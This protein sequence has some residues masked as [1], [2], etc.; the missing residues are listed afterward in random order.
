MSKHYI[1]SHR[2]ALGWMK[3]PHD[4]R[5]FPLS[6]P[7]LAS[8][9]DKV[10]LRSLTP[11]IYDQGYIGSCTANAV[12]RMLAMLAKQ[13][14]YP[15]RTFIYNDTRILEGSLGFDSGAYMRDAVKVIYNDGACPDEDM[16]YDGSDFPGANHID[17]TKPSTK[18]YSDAAPWKIASYQKVAQTTNGMRATLASGLAFVFGVYIYESF[19]TDAVAATGMVPLPKSNDI[20]LGGHALT[21][22]GYDSTR[23]LIIVANSWGD[24]WGDKGFCYFP[25]SYLIDSRY[26]SDFYTSPGLRNPVPPDPTPPPQPDPIEPPVPVDPN[27]IYVDLPDGFIAKRITITS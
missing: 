20:P 6:L 26:A 2:R 21:A 14:L 3:S 22:V 11:P 7:R 15:S 8:L 27:T 25:E 24:T 1:S 18:C 4:P 13:K 5:D 23:G 17:T 10:D 16:P 9:P 19:M 12:A